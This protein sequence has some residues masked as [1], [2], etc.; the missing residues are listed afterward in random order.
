M[1]EPDLPPPT[2]SY[3]LGKQSQAGAIFEGGHPN[4]ATLG[5]FDDLFAGRRV[6]FA[7]NT[8]TAIRTACDA[9]GLAPPHLPMT[10]IPKTAATRSPWIL[11]PWRDLLLIIDPPEFVV[12]QAGVV[13]LGHLP[14]A[15]Q[16]GRL[17]VAQLAEVT[18]DDAYPAHP[19]ARQERG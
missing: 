2:P 3:P 4:V 6:H 15:E 18:L 11:G 10:A 1:T 12:D 14:G 7:F 8:R 9:L 16:G 5:R 19:G 17:Q 13:L